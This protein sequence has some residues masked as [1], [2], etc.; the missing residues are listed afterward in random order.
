M[1]VG[2]MSFQSNLVSGRNCVS[3]DKP[4]SWF[5]TRVWGDEK[6]VPEMTHRGI[7]PEI[8]PIC[9][10]LL[11]LSDASEEELPDEADCSVVRLVPGK[12]QIREVPLCS[13][14]VAT[15]DTCETTSC[16]FTLPQ[17]LTL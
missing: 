9:P 5:V 12:C 6:G 16:F 7:S 14:L 17:T 11:W 4:S 13:S 2:V 3:M 1:A 15:C 10:P 8:N